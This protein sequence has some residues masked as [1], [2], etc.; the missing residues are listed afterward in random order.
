MQTQ[1][2]ITRCF[3]AIALLIAL[4][5][6]V[7]PI[8]AW[9]A[10]VWETVGS[11]GFSAGA[12]SYTSLALDG[13]GTP[14]VAYRDGGNSDKATVMKFNGTNWDNVGSP[15]FS[16]GTA[17]YTS[18]AFDGSGTPYVAYQDGDN[19]NKVTVMKFNGENWEKV[20]SPG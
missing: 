3:L 13:A 5:A 17:S 18:L 10:G 20:G 14:Y 8:T 2:I 1:K 4:F 9:A 19:S 11:A 16:L 7:A 6:L 15:G 12:A